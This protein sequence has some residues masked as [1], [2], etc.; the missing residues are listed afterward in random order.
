MPTRATT[1]ISHEQL[2]DH[3]IERHPHESIKRGTENQVELV[4]VGAVNAGDRELGLGYAQMA[5]LGDRAS[6]E[7]ALAL[8]KK[9]ESEG[10]SDAAVH[11]RLGFLEQI[12]GRLD[13]AQRE[14]QAAL[15]ENPYES[16]ALANLAVIEAASGD[17]G[18]A[19][20]L[21]ERAVTADPSQTTAGL[22][23]AF[24]L[25]KVGQKSAALQTIDEVKRFNPDSP[26]VQAFL[27][28]GKYSGQTCRV[29]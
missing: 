14:Y 29:K 12:S 3:D 2:T 21:L 19:M 7:R 27:E 22:D 28:N 4:P 25:C 9:A 11:V 6:G 26:A 18:S 16:T 8:L 24:L 1:D 15:Q 20:K 23:L 13:A 17:A 10:A 5:E